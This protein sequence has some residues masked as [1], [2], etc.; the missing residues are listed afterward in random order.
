M[1]AIWKSDNKSSSCDSCAIPFTF[2]RRRH[3]CRNCGDIFCNTCSTRR[4]QG[5]RGYGPLERV[6]VC[7]RCAHVGMS[8]PVPIFAKTPAHS[9][10]WHPLTRDC[11]FL[12][13]G[14][15]QSRDFAFGVPNIP[16]YGELTVRVTIDSG[17]LNLIAMIPPTSDFF[18]NGSAWKCGCFPC[19]YNGWEQG[20]DGI[21]T[22]CSGDMTIVI[23]RPEG[24]PT[25]C[26]VSKDHPGDHPPVTMNNFPPEYLLAIGFYS[27]NVLR[28]V[29]VD[30]PWNRIK[31]YVLVVH[32]ILQNRARSRSLI[33]GSPRPTSTP[34]LEIVAHLPWDI[35]MHIFAWV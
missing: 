18:M 35:V 5:V 4:R 24:G 7:D 1:S 12:P 26:T 28:I 6:R 22:E 2:F 8:L 11:D 29:S 27:G 33:M 10:L 34:L 25:S 19:G 14:S 15:L 23:K 30:G 20:E 13:D 16:L 17:C 9:V 3:H 31:G 32:L 21:E